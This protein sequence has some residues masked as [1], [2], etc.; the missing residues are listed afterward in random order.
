[1]LVEVRIE[2]AR[3]HAAGSG[4]D[5][6]CGPD[7]LDGI[8]EGSAVVAFVADHPERG[9]AGN[10]IVSLCDIA[11]L[12]AGQDEA[13]RPAVAIDGKMDLGAQPSSG[14]PQSRILSPPFPVA[15]C[16]CAR[17]MVVSIIR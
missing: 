3:A 14:A 5:N 11:D 16:W 2:G 4:W 9:E 12:A 8:E 7:S 15:A 6:G 10:Q 17:T 1:M 13:D